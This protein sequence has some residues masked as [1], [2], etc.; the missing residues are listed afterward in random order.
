M[1]VATENGPY[2]I[3]DPL[4]CQTTT[5]NFLFLRIRTEFGCASQP[6]RYFLGVALRLGLG[7]VP[8]EILAQ[9][10]YRDADC[11]AQPLPV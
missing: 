7:L 4:D 3:S 8:A 2:S 9:A 5:T 6:P 10:R 11:Q 1:A